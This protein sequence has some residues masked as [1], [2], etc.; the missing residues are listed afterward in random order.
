[1]K[2]VTEADRLYAIEQVSKITAAMR[3]SAGAA[4]PVEGLPGLWCIFPKAAMET[5]AGLLDRANA[6][7]LDGPMPHD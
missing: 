1:M 5:A 4:R 7:I 6:I 2:P 3:V